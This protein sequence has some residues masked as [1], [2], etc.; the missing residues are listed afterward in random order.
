MPILPH[1]ITGATQW[2]PAYQPRYPGSQSPADDLAM[3]RLLRQGGHIPTGKA[4]RKYYNRSMENLQASTG[5]MQ[6]LGQAENNLHSLQQQSQQ[7]AT[8]ALARAS[9]HNPFFGPNIARQSFRF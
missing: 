5:Y 7:M 2:F 4:V 9:Q 8:S 3:D 6:S 1:Q